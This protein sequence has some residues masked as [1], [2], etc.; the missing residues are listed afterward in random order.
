MYKSIFDI[1]L[2]LREIFEIMPGRASSY[3]H[4]AASGGRDG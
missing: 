2:L 3:L 4:N 1:L